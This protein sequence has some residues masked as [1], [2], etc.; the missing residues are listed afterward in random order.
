MPVFGYFATVT[1]AELETVKLGGRRGKTKR[2][3][4]NKRARA[5]RRRGR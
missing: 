4:A 2:R 1:P 5:A 3:T